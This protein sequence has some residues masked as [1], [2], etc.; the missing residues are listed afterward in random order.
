MSLHGH[1]PDRITR[2]SR[3]RDISLHSVIRSIAKDFF[4]GFN[5][6]PCFFLP[7]RCAQIQ[8][9]F[10]VGIIPYAF[11]VPVLYKTVSPVDH[12]T[13][14][15]F[16]QYRG[17]FCPVRFSRNGHCSLR[18]DRLNRLYGI[19]AFAGP[20]LI[21]PVDQPEMAVRG[22]DSSAH[23]H[24]QRCRG[25]RDQPEPFFLPDRFLFLPFRHQV[26]HFI[27]NHFRKAFR[28]IRLMR[29]QRFFDIILQHIQSPPSPSVFSAR[30]AR[31]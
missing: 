19:L 28:G 27:I 4:Q 31:G 16:H 17:I 22:Q 20:D 5:G 6:I 3:K 2:F 21:R 23:H 26:K 13:F 1:R 24:Y 10:Q 7:F 15:L 9:S 12:I 8:H 25:H 30:S 14:V 29:L 11:P 18:Q